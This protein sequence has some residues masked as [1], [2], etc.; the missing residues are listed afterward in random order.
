MMLHRRTALAALAALPLAARAQEAKPIRLLVGFP[1]G[2]GTDAIA[3]VLAE[4][5]QASL[6]TTVIVENKPGAGGQIAA[7]ALKQAPPD[8]STLFLS[9]D[10]TISILPLVLKNPGFDPARDFLPV[11][12][13]ATFANAL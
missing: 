12:G 11:A 3:R 5:L 7:Q 13:F 10:H 8:G 2:G 4:A 1:A 9:H 6:G